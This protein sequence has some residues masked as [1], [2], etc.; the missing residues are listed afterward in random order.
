MGDKQRLLAEAETAYAEIKEAIA[1]LDEARM[2]R[3]WLGAWGIREILIHVSGWHREM[4][5]ALRRIAGGEP[6]YPEGESYDDA[7]AWN[8]RF[9]A[10]RKSVAMAAILDE[11]ERSHRDFVAAAAAVPEEHFATGGAAKDLFEGS[12]TQHYREHAEQILRWREREVA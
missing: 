7:D 9:V 4:T 12:S 8:A 11:L 1:S 5:P 2:S 3:I 6:S 10:A